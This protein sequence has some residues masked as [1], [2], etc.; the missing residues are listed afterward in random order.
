[1]VVGVEGV[2]GKIMPGGVFVVVMGFLIAPW[3]NLRKTAPG[4]ES[5]G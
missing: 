4:A 2:G 3:N 5:K 1:M